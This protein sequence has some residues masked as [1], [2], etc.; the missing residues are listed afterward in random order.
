MTVINGLARRDASLGL[1]SPDSYAHTH[2][3]T[4][5]A[6]YVYWFPVVCTS[7][8]LDSVGNHKATALFCGESQLLT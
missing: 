1:I 8:V 3:I 6:R 5:F 2:H 4:T 7:W